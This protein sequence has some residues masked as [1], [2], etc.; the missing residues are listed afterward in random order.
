M[1]LHLPN[2]IVNNSL[3]DAVPVEQNYNLIQ[4]YINNEI[5]NRD[6]SVAMTG[7]LLLA[8]SPTQPNHAVNKTYADAIMP[9][10][11]MMPWP[12]PAAPAGNWRLCNGASL[13]VASYP[14]LHGVIGYSYGGSGG[15][16]LLPNTTG[17]V[18][19]AVDA[20][21]VGMNAVGKVGGTWVM[22]VPA[23]VHPMPHTH[24]HPHTHPIPH[25]HS[26][27]H[28]H[29]PFNTSNP[30]VGHRHDQSQRQNSTPGNTGSVM[31]ASA[32]GTTVAG[33]TGNDDTVHQHQGNV[34][35]YAGNSGPTLTPN[36]GAVSEATTGGVSTP[37]TA[38]TGV[39]GAEHLPPFVTINYI[40][41]IA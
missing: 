21:R 24:E 25:V 18:L 20:A 40:I 11:I 34:P 17:R 8:G 27:A 38:S 29:A 15:S 33:V 10:G 41:R 12:G 19:V 39:A 9:V 32:T 1:P 14:A 36:S 7:P 6:G 28:D 30:L 31:M 23:H 16:F 22:P 4:D 26:I 35:P 5:I 37:N 2:D 3:A 13:A